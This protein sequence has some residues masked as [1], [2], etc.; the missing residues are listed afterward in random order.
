MGT[1]SMGLSD[2]V[3]KG[4]LENFLKELILFIPVDTLCDLECIA[5][6]PFL[7]CCNIAL[8][9]HTYDMHKTH[10]FREYYLQKSVYQ[11][12]CG[13]ECVH[14]KQEKQCGYFKMYEYVLLAQ[15]IYKSL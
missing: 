3:N 12:N 11:E 9:K 6:P 10:Y 4:I 8:Q 5:I 2:C 13:R 14:E 15:A 1:R 7:G